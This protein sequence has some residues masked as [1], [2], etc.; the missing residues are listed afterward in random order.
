MFNSEKPKSYEGAEKVS[1]KTLKNLGNASIDL[2]RLED[3]KEAKN[4]SENVGKEIANTNEKIEALK[5]EMEEL[6]KQEAELSREKL[7]HDAEIA[8]INTARREK[9]KAM[10]RGVIGM[11]GWYNQHPEE[12]DEIV[13][14]EMEHDAD[15]YR[16]EHEKT[17]KSFY[18]VVRESYR[19][20]S[21]ANMKDEIEGY[22]DRE[23]D[24]DKII[25]QT[26]GIV[27]KADGIS[28]EN[29]GTVKVLG[30][31]KAE[32]AEARAE[33]ARAHEQKFLIEEYRH[34]FGNQAA[35]AGADETV[36]E[37]VNE[38]ADET[39]NVMNA[40][41]AAEAAK[42]AAV[43]NSLNKDINS[44]VDDMLAESENNMAN[45]VNKMMDEEVEIFNNGNFKVFVPELN[46]MAETEFNG[47]IA[48]FVEL[49]N[50]KVDENLE[51]EDASGSANTEGE[52]EAE[53]AKSAEKKS[54]VKRIFSKLKEKFGWGKEG[55]DQDEK[56]PHGAQDY[57][58]PRKANFKKHLAVSAAMITLV[59]GSLASLDLKMN[60]DVQAAETEQTIEEAPDIDANMKEAM[61]NDVVVNCYSVDEN[62]NKHDI[63]ADLTVM[64]KDRAGQVSNPFDAEVVGVGSQQTATNKELPGSFGSIIEAGELSGDT[65]A[66][67][68]NFLGNYIKRMAEQ[69]Q[70]LADFLVRTDALAD[71]NIPGV[72]F[73]STKGGASMED[74]NHDTQIIANMSSEQRQELLNKASSKLKELAEGSE[75]RAVT[76]PGGTSYETTHME[77]MNN[78]ELRFAAG[79]SSKDEDFMV[80]QIIKD[81]KSICDNGEEKLNALKI[82]GLVSDSAVLGSEEANAAM[83]KYTVL[84]LRNKCG[85]QFV[86][87]ENGTTI[88]VDGKEEVV[89]GSTSTSVETPGTPTPETPTPET[90]TPDNPTPTPPTPTP[91]TPPTPLAGKTGTNP[92]ARNNPSV[93]P[94]TK[95]FEEESAENGGARIVQAGQEQMPEVDTSGVNTNPEAQQDWAEAPTE[96]VRDTGTGGT[97][98]QSTND[99]AAAAELLRQT[100]EAL[101]TQ[102]GN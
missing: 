13:R 29:R 60:N 8:R 101:R 34:Y 21:L 7:H 16:E 48:K 11:T 61:K 14:P 59:I 68:K 80:I 24:I 100:E 6:Q 17:G 18:D 79:Q 25:A 12:L 31:S 40:A 30:M 15:Y 39:A 52:A 35:E 47:K 45:T 81:G 66:V 44:E 4:K 36:D 86:I 51:S 89:G 23:A 63:T 58:G 27:D 70:L 9:Q 46:D 67:E 97:I 55:A 85:G 99:N 77:K 32:L 1:E 57:Y 54:A 20:G 83:D 49:V 42:N 65:N 37:T 50:V 69:P 56:K 38:S 53:K 82:N 87:V 90:P 10:N 91:P 62:G 74:L 26:Q 5:A 95:S 102:R 84:G 72:E 98:N 88:M 93:L 2:Y 94:I 96:P 92:W 75:I 64:N 28:D 71:I 19:I 78:G 33:N 73:A 22:M 76:I 43:E 41:D 3:E